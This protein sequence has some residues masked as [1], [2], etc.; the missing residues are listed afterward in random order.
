M[1]IVSIDE[2]FPT[3]QLNGDDVYITSSY[4]HY[5]LIKE[6]LKGTKIYY[7]SI[8]TK[9]KFN[10]FFEYRD[11]KIQTKSYEFIRNE[12]YLLIS[13]NENKRIMKNF[14][15]EYEVFEK[16]FKL[17]TE[18]EELSQKI[19]ALDSK[20]DKELKKE[21]KSQ[22]L[23]FEKKLS[24]INFWW[25]IFLFKKWSPIGTTTFCGKKMIVLQ[26]K[27][28][29][30]SKSVLTSKN[31][32][33]CHEKYSWLKDSTQ[34]EINLEDLN[35]S[36]PSSTE[37]NQKITRKFIEKLSK[38]SIPSIKKDFYKIKHAEEIEKTLIP[39]TSGNVI[40]MLFS[41]ALDTEIETEEGTFLLKG[42]TYKE[43][44]SF[45]R[46]YVE[47]LKRSLVVLNMDS[48]EITREGID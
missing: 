47:N 23:T 38:N 34:H 31:L 46:G 1:K 5:R 17:V 8:T 42:S 43:K 18:E 33:E 29:L 36:M 26:K 25:D 39:A 11:K 14:R 16:F 24:N 9:K 21:L 45:G 44:K 4:K 13:K 22:L 28:S 19:K 35:C 48:Y 37:C 12:G 15:S 10:N 32:L 40:N 7:E 30:F 2:S 41:G 27:P 6:E 20:K 3:E